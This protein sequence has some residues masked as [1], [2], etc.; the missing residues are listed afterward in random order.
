MRLGAPA[1]GDGARI[2]REAEGPNLGS[3]AITSLV[4]LLG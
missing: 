1:F 3:Q 4:H 2:V